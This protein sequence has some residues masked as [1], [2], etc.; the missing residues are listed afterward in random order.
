M[1]A[2][3]ALSPFFMW[4]HIFPCIRTCMCALLIDIGPILDDRLKK[5]ILKPWKGAHS[6]HSVCVSVC[7]CVCVFVC[8]CVSVCLCVC[9]CVC[10]CVWVICKIPVAPFS[11]SARSHNLHDALFL[12]PFRKR[13]IAKR[14]ILLLWVFAQNSYFC[15]GHHL[16]R[17]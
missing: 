5:K 15:C 6:S 14:F 11:H 12:K 13:W 9:V 8:L 4:A 2:W 7:P 1:M 17:F 16:V 3:W 10:V